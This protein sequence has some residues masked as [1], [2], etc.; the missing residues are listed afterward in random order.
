MLEA[1]VNM[2]HEVE[3]TRIYSNR[4]RPS[5]SY[6]YLRPTAAT[7]PRLVLHPSSSPPRGPAA[8]Q[9]MSS[10]ATKRLR[11]KQR[12]QSAGLLDRPLLADLLEEDANGV[13]PWSA[14]KGGKTTEGK[15]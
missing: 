1:P 7:S 9:A 13:R 10:P 3:M 2:Q 11:G 8:P 6:A 12:P 14:Q 5:M 15:R 4:Q